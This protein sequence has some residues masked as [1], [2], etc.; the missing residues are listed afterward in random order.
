MPVPI[1]LILR[2]AVILGNP[3]A[4]KIALPQLLTAGASNRGGY[5]RFA[6]FAD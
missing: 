2:D 4:G 5:E 6:R 3:A 1:L